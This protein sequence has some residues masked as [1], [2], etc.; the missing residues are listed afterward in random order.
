M[1]KFTTAVSAALTCL[2]C[3]EANLEAH[4]NEQVEA[5]EDSKHKAEQRLPSGA[6]TTLN[7]AGLLIASFDKDGDLVVNVEEYGGGR[8]AN[9]MMADG[10]GNGAISLIELQGWRLHAL[11]SLDASPS[12]MAFDRNFDQTISRVEFDEMFGH[13]FETHDVNADRELAFSELMRVIEIPDRR[14]GARAERGE[15]SRRE[16]GGGRRGR[17]IGG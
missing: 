1:I 13:I 7:T 17:N 5:L 11:G 3:L 9:F 6:V 4:A 16:K 12:N 2:I 14:S 8:D 10:D 15:G